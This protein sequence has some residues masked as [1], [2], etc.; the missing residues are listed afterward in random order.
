MVKPGWALYPWYSKMSHIPG[1]TFAVSCRTP[2][3]VSVPG[4]HLVTKQKSEE[5]RK[6]KKEKKEDTPRQR[7]VF[8]LTPWT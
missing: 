6:K 2:S 3:S 1:M 5:E 8:Q 7:R 4:R